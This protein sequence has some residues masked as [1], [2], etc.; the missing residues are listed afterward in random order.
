MAT[1]SCRILHYGDS[2]I[3]GDR[4]TAYL[5]NRLQGMY[6]GNGPGFIPIKQVYNQISA[7][8]KPSKN[9]IRYA[10]FDRRAKK[11]LPHRKYGT[12]MS[13][14]RF[15]PHIDSLPVQHILD[16]LPVHHATINISKTK[17]SYFTLRKFKTIG[18]HYGNCLSP[19]GVK[20]FE[21]DVI[22]QQDS[23]RVDG[24]YHYYNI[25]LSQV[26]DNVRIELEG[27]ISA[28]F[29]GLTMDGGVG[30]QIDNVA[31]RGGS[32]TIFSG[33]SAENYALM[34]QQ[35]DPKIVIMQY[36]RNTVPYLKDSTSVDKYRR[37]ISK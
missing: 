21:N 31:M 2:Q 34:A 3:E 25:R 16:S 12:Y 26:P 15:T 23:L 17:L 30:V 14:S 11:K 1:G 33:T 10:M 29:Y 27:K 19:V 13:L 6:G 7:Q 9:W 8:V 5:R 28:D 18:L 22:I 37:R 36:G 4:I 20:V 24:K 35:L 32:G